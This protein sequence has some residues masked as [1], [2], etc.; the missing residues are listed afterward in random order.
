MEPVQPAAQQAVGHHGD[1]MQPSPD[2]KGPVRPMPQPRGQKDH[3]GVDTGPRQP[4]PAAA[5]RNVE[6][7]GEKPRHGHVPA[8]PKAPDGQRL[9]GHIKV[10]R[11]GN[12][13][14]LSNAPGHVRV[15]AE[16]KVELQR[17]AQRHRQ[18]R[19]A[20][21]GRQIGPAPVRAAAKSLCHNDLLPNP[22][23][24][25]PQAL[26]NALGGRSFSLDRPHL[27]NHLV[28][29]GNGAG[30]YTGEKAHKAGILQQGIVCRVSSVPVH[31]ESNL[32]KGKETD[33][34]GQQ[35]RQRP[36]GGPQQPVEV[37]Q[38]KVGVLKVTQ[39]A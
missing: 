30:G 33:P 39:Q 18:G 35:Q 14:H 12:P 21:E 23:G 20:V 8:L 1:P 19:G 11:Q 16:I 9:V 32:L 37:V 34:Q 4:P 25:Q 7:P 6:I 10:L 15:A 22:Q 3:Q 2:H 31:Q 36:D 27:G 5:Q 24:E 13:Q 28:M 26:G 29:E 17:V 38:K